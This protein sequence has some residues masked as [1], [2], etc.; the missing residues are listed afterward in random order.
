MMKKT[1]KITISVP[2]D[3]TIGAHLSGYKKVGFCLLGYF[4]INLSLSLSL[5]LSLNI[6]LL[7]CYL[8]F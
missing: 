1:T 6:Y 5:S 3:I 4:I 7:A 8:S 2:E